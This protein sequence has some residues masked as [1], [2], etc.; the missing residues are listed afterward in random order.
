MNPPNI[1]VFDT[2]F[3][4][5][6]DKYDKAL[7]EGYVR[8][9]MEEH[10]PRAGLNSFTATM[11]WP[12]DVEYVPPSPPEP[13]PLTEKQAIEKKLLET[14]GEGQIGAAIVRGTGRRA[15]NKKDKEKP[16]DQGAEAMPE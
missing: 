12:D 1:Q 13:K 3:S 4:L 2:L 11:T 14:L 15:Y 10:R 8:S 6:M 16:A 9:S 5:F 7:A